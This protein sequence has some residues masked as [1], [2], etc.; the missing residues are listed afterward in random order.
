MSDARAVA[1]RMHHA[2]AERALRQASAHR[3]LRDRLVCQLRAEDPQRWSYPRLARAVGCS[4]ELIA[5]I[6]RTT[7]GVSSPDETLT[8]P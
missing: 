6:V 1:A 8:V 3:H 2:D 5:H 7:P 4:P